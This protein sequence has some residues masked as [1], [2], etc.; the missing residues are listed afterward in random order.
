MENEIRSDVEGTIEAILVSEGEA[1]E[2]GA[3]LLKNFFKLNKKW[4]KYAIYFNPCCFI[5]S[6]TNF[7]IFR[8]LSN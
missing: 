6:F 1:V 5:F 8:W 4:R 2:K 7:D 3:E